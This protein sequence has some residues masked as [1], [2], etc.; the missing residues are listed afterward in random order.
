MF[1]ANGKPGDRSY[2]ATSKF[3]EDI[4][5]SGDVHNNPYFD[6]NLSIQANAENMARYK[7]HK[8]N[9]M[10]YKFGVLPTFNMVSR[11]FLRSL[12]RK[13]PTEPF[14]TALGFSFFGIRLNF[15]HVPVLRLS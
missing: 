7:F 8:E 4:Q 13:Q 9:T 5:I 15:S 14:W 3:S 10:K 2:D 6:F 1:A 11:I 12:I